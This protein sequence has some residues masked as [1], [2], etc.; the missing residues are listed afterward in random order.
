[1]IRQDVRFVARRGPPTAMRFARPASLL[2]WNTAKRSKTLKWSRRMNRRGLQDS[3]TE[4]A[5]DFTF[6]EHC[7]TY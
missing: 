5:G 4:W 2:I 7:R 6:D 1:M 3:I